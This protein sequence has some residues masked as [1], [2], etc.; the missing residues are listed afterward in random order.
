MK[1]VPYNEA[2]L[3]TTK[4]YV[5]FVNYIG[6]YISAATYNEPGVEADD[7]QIILVT[8]SRF[9][10]GEEPKSLPPNAPYTWID[11]EDVVRT[12]A[13]WW[14]EF[15]A[16]SIEFK[17]EYPET[18]AAFLDYTTNGWGICGPLDIPITEE[19]YGIIHADAHT[20]NW[21]IEAMANNEYL[22]TVIDFDNMQ[23]AWYIVDPG[24]SIWGANMEMWFDLMEDREEKI[25]QMEEWFLDEYGYD[26]THQE[27]QQ[28]CEWRRRFMHALAYG[29]RTTIPKTDPNY[30]SLTTYLDLDDAGLVP[31]C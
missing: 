20:G 4:N 1:S 11:N 23:K 6:K 22:E 21:M 16:R 12:E 14:H 10:P 18:N 13:A 24:T 2:V 26:T 7:D 25:N 30:W 31:T 27:L 15:R 17:T 3:A 19:S 9:A 28:G 29:V 5:T 8:V